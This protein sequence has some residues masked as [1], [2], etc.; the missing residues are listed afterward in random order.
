M[1]ENVSSFKANL[2]RGVEHLAESDIET[3]RDLLRGYGSSSSILKEL[4]QNAEDAEASRLDFIYVPPDEG[5]KHALTR[6]PSLLVANNGVFREEHR[7][8]I[9]LINLGTKGTDDRA[10]GRF[11]RGLKSVFAWCEAFFITAQTDTKLGWP[12]S[13]ITDLFNPWHGWRHR[14]WEEEFEQE[15][16]EITARTKRYVSAIYCRQS[17]GLD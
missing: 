16:S 10:I 17:Q 12:A 13:S 5:A 11:G 9:F 2:S 7:L 3:I 4:I 1:A 6:G 15:V 8:A 14:N